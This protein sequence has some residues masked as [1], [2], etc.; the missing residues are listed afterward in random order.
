VI[1]VRVSKDDG[2]NVHSVNPPGNDVAGIIILIALEHS[3]VN[4]NR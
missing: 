4:K 2:I 1:Q 3:E